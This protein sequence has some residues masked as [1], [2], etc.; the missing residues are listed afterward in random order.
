MN[1]SYETKKKFKTQE[2]H[3]PI[4]TILVPLVQELIWEQM[5]SF[6]NLLRGKQKKRQN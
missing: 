3:I 4:E 5:Q 6:H 2:K 1:K